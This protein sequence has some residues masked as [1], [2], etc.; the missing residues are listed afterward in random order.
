[1]TIAQRQ[2]AVFTDLKG[3]AH[4]PRCPRLDEESASSRRFHPAS[5]C[6]KRDLSLMTLVRGGAKLLRLRQP[7]TPYR[8]CRQADAHYQRRRQQQHDQ[9][10]TASPVGGDARRS[11]SFL[12]AYLRHIV[13]VAV[14]LIEPPP[15][16]CRGLDQ[17]GRNALG[18]TP[19]A[20]RLY[21]KRT[22]VSRSWR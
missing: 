3:I 8:S 2:L 5:R 18:S 4:P 15:R 20:G 13:A 7:R 1:M 11:R 16:C 21:R 17:R 12:M 19:R 10:R 14:L 9:H 6:A 22:S